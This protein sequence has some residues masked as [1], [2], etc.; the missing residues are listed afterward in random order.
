MNLICGP[1]KMIDRLIDPERI[2]EGQDRH[3]RQKQ[4]SIKPPMTR[5][6]HAGTPPAPPKQ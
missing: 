6:T 1:I 3:D 4:I 5:A 2:E